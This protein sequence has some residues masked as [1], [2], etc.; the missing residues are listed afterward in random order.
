MLRLMQSFSI[1]FALVLY[2][3]CSMDFVAAGLG[4]TGSGHAGSKNFPFRIDVLTS[5]P[6]S[7]FLFRYAVF[8]RKHSENRP[9]SFPSPQSNLTWGAFSASLIP[10]KAFL[11]MVFLLPNTF[12]I[13]FAPD[14]AFSSFFTSN[15]PIFPGV[16]LVL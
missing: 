12:P 15:F 11:R 8:S 9:P 7:R 16:R 3:A 10:E 5:P 14:G 1:L 4:P 13:L 2:S 6:L